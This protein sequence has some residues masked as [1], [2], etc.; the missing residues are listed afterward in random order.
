MVYTEQNKTQRPIPLPPPELPALLEIQTLRLHLRR[1]RE[2][3]EAAFVYF[4][5]ASEDHL[6][7]WTP[8][9]SETIT[10]DQ[11]FQV[12]R[13]RALQGLRNGDQLHLAAFL[14]TGQIAGFFNLNNIIRGVFQNTYAGWSISA[15]LVGRGLGTEG[16]LALLDVAF[17][18]PPM[19]LALHRVQANVIPE[20]VPSIRVAEKAGFRREG[21]ARNYLKIAGIWQDH[22]MFAKL[23][24][25]HTIQFGS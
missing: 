18:P 7:P 10:H 2:A 13:L 23:A 5:E 12:Q 15:E 8:A 24:S 9:R 16:V 3:D 25:E 4:H 20:N 19:G 17:A 6:R 1:L 21:L 22:I 11:L 14:P